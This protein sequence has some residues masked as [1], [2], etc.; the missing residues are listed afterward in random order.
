MPENPFPVPLDPARF[1]FAEKI[2]L[3]VG[4]GEDVPNEEFL[5]RVLIEAHMVICADGGLDL[6]RSLNGRVDYIVGDFDS[7]RTKDLA[8]YEKEGIVRRF[9]T[10]KDDTD[11]ELAIRLAREEGDAT[12]LMLGGRG[13]RLDHSMA[14][15]AL[16]KNSASAGVRLVMRTATNQATFLSSGQYILPLPP[17]DWYTSFVTFSGRA[18]LSLKGF[19]YPLKDFTLQPGSLGVSNHIFDVNNLVV[20]DAEEGDG[21][22]CIQST[23]GSRA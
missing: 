8:L 20:V 6:V 13:S 3:I 19:E 7:S 23:D 16:L 5:K 14:N 10:R 15:L 2:A 12:I 11:M 4:A 18:C 17:E 9:P 21:V 1:P 22:F